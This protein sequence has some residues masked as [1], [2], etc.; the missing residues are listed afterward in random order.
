MWATNRLVWLR[1][2][3]NDNGD[4][5]AFVPFPLD[6]EGDIFNPVAIA[7]RSTAELLNDTRHRYPFNAI[8]GDS[9][10]I[11]SPRDRRK[12]LRNPAPTF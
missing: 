8:L 3:G 2:G 11:P 1:H 9:L 10:K 4:F 5:V 7:D 12:I 6:P